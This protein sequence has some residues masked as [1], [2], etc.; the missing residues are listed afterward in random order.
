MEHVVERG[1]GKTDRR[2]NA[3][4]VRNLPERLRRQPAVLLLCEPQRRN[5]RRV[6]PVGKAL[7]HNIYGPSELVAHRSTSPI[8]VSSEPTIAIMSATSASRMQVAV[9]CSATK[10]GARNLTRQGRGPPSEAT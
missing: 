6:R 1:D 2:R 8:T 10:D 9:A 7:A 5:Q 3:D 4:G